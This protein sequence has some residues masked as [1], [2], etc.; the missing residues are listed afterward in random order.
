VTGVIHDGPTTV[1][2][3]AEAVT[4]SRLLARAIEGQALSSETRALLERIGLLAQLERA[5]AA[6]R[7]V[8]PATS[9]DGWLSTAQAAALAGITVRGMQ[10]RAQHG[11]VA[12]ARRGRRLVIDATSL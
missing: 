3:G 6:A 7:L 11:L 5:R 2:T 4:L 10:K 8:D 1:L 12:S 9:V